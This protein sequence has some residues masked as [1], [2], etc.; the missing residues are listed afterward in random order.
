MKLDGKTAL[1]M[2]V[3]AA[4]LLYRLAEEDVLA[5][6]TFD[7][8]KVTVSFNVC[9]ETLFDELENKGLKSNIVSFE[10]KIFPYEKFINMYTEDG[11]VFRIF[12]LIPTHKAQEL[13]LSVPGDDKDV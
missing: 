4:K 3:E 5:N 10:S 7:G 1:E 9:N 11:Q 6:T 8:G 12:T 2:M 13:D